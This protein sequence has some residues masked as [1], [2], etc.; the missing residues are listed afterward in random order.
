MGWAR[1]NPPDAGA[2]PVPDDSDTNVDEATGAAAVGDEP[3]EKKAGAAAMQEAIA[4]LEQS[5]EFAKVFKY[6]PYIVPVA[7][8]LSALTWGTSIYIMYK[9]SKHY[10]G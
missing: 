9:K 3:F 1:R 10:Y 5:P 6:L 7:I 4:H 2:P 8:G